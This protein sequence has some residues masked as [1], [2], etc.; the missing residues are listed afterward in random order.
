MRKAHA[1]GERQLPGSGNKDCSTGLT[2][3]GEGKFG[4][5]TSWISC[6][7]A[8]FVGWALLTVRENPYFYVVG[9]AH[10]KGFENGESSLVGGFP[11]PRGLA[12]VVRVRV[13]EACPDRDSACPDR[14]SACPDRDSACPFGLKPCPKGSGLRR[15]VRR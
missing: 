15:A 12:F 8:I 11:T 13:R 9:S 7:L 4:L 2:A 14:D 10:P 1:K 5:L 3:R 6:F